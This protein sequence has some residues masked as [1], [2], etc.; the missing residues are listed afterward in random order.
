M[1]VSAKRL[2]L[3]N[4]DEFKRNQADTVELDSLHHVCLHA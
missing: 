2:D 3:Y 4:F 1:G